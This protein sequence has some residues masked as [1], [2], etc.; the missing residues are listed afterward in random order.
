MDELLKYITQ[1]TEWKLVENDEEPDNKD[2]S[3]IRNL[4]YKNY[5]CRFYLTAE[6]NNGVYFVFLET[7]ICDKNNVEIFNGN[8]FIRRLDSIVYNSPVNIDAVLQTMMIEKLDALKLAEILY[9]FLNSF[10]DL[11]I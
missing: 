2:I 1:L 6:Y 7:Y 9:T 4:K 10:S 3:Y 8:H 5:K 11:Y